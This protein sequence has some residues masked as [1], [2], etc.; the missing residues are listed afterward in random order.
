MRKIEIFP[1]NFHLVHHTFALKIVSSLSVFS[2]SSAITQL[3][4]SFFSFRIFYENSHWDS[5][6]IFYDCW[7]TFFW[8]WHLPFKLYALLLIVADL[9]A[10]EWVNIVYTCGIFS[11]HFHVHLNLDEI[12]QK[13]FPTVKI[14]LNF[15]WNFV[16]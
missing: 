2:S 7:V 5:F 12:M 8:T 3:N 10:D 11:G 13:I 1:A 9:W 16:Q 14:F 6:I 4:F 15:K